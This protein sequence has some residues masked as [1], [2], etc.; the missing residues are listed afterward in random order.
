MSISYKNKL[1]SKFFIVIPRYLQF[2]SGSKKNVQVKNINVKRCS[3]LL[4]LKTVKKN[5]NFFALARICYLISINQ[6]LTNKQIIQ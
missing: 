2:F 5:Y 3:R 6:I 4:Q 1:I